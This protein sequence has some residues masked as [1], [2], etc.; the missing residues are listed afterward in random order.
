M[1]DKIPISFFDD[2]RDRYAYAQVDL[3]FG[4]IAD[5]LQESLDDSYA[6]K[7]AAPLLA[8]CEFTESRRLKANVL[9]SGM[10]ILDIDDGMQIDEAAERVT[11]AGVA[12]FI[13][14]TASHRDDRHKFRVGLP[15]ARAVD[16]ETYRSA[17]AAWNFV[18]DEVA[19]PSKRGAE[20]LFYLPGTYPSG[21]GRFLQF[22]GSILT[23]DD[24][25]NVIGLPVEETRP[26]ELRSPGKGRSVASQ[27]SMSANERASIDCSESKSIYDSRLV[28]D[29][30]INAYL[31]TAQNWYHARYRFMCSVAATAARRRVPI[32][33]FE[34]R[35]LF[36]QLD[37]IDGGFYGS[38]EDQ[39]ALLVEAQRA[40]GSMKHKWSV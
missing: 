11:E 16:A 15:L 9:R 38:A 23:A 30:A 4:E 39:Q 1:E 31:D 2:V 28:S 6:S 27:S 12:A 25:I 40:I 32:T 21:R 26:I 8:S 20:S 29:S 34:L 37:Q 10:V 36:N 35:D 19:D 18:F 17:W 3:E 33:A 5:I 24:L 13:Y 7:S 14:T 22:S